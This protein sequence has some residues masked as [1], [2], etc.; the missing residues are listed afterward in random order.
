MGVSLSPNE[1][2]ST[3]R[4]G[5]ETSLAREIQN[6]ISRCN[7]RYNDISKKEVLE[8]RTNCLDTLILK[9]LL[10]YIGSVP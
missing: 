9:I 10:R 2:H 4:N 8:G 5:N 1:T 3:D 7:G 6:R